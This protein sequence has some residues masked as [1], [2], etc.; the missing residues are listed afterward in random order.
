M[1]KYPF[2]VIGGRMIKTGIA[3]LITGWICLYFGLPPAFAVM[4]A[5]VTIEPTVIDSIRKGLIRF[6]A[7]MIGAFISII[8]SS[9][10]GPGA[11]TYGLAAVLTLY[12]CHFFR[13]QEGALVATLTAIAMI[14]ELSG[15]YGYDFLL[16]VTN[17][18]IGLIVST[19]INVLIWPPNYLKAIEMRR[20]HFQKNISRVLSQSVQALLYS[21]NKGRSHRVA[22]A[23]LLSELDELFRL[24]AYQKNESVFHYMN[25]REKR[26]FIL[27]QKKLILL[28]RI[29]FSIGQLQTINK[30]PNFSTAAKETISDFSKDLA[31]CLASEDGIIAERQYETLAKLSF[32]LKPSIKIRELQPIKT[33]YN[34]EPAS[35]LYIELLFIHDCLE[36][37]EQWLTRQAYENRNQAYDQPA[38]YF[39]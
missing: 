30:Q 26:Q 14:P 9:M 31:D 36:D 33:N 3:V 10:F 32:Y 17:T 15:H 28:Q 5:I 29:L 35:T 12:F 37:I 21:S 27:E 34:F 6:P 16:R 11:L 8:L 39:K 20:H 7:S 22:Y 2:P 25:Q 4:T 18:S 38:R 13:L 24:L 23:S 1:N 19:L